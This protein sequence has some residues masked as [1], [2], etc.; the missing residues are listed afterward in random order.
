MNR[1]KECRVSSALTD[2]FKGAGILRLIVFFGIHLGVTLG[3]PYYF[4]SAGIITLFWP[5]TGIAL[6]ATLAGG[7]PYAIATLLSCAVAGWPP[8]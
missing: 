7:Y 6:A 5:A 8:F 3:A 4:S 1:A 2:T